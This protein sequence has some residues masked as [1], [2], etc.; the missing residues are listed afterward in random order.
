V[1]INLST[2]IGTLKLSNPIMTASGTFGY[3]DE[4]HETF[5]DISRLGAVVTK[6]ISLQPRAGNAMPRVIE[7]CSGMINAIGLA[8]V[9]LDA[10]LSDKLPFLNSVK[11]TVIVNVLGSSIEEYV[12]ICEQLNQAKNIAAIE[13]NISCPNVNSGGVHFGTQPKLTESVIRAVQAV[14]TLPL[15]VKLSPQVTSIADIARAAEN[16]GANAISL[17]NTVPAMVIDTKKRKP[18]LANKIGGLSGPAIKPIAIKQ[19]YDVY[20]NV[21]IP[22]IGMCGITCLND[23]IEFLLAGASAVQI[24]T[25]NFTDPMLASQLIDELANYCQAHSIS[26]ISKLIG[27]AHKD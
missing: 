27:Q 21:K 10:F 18:V 7:V 3:G 1:D 22:I 5:Y 24:G 25:A 19:V 11:A 15:I 17:I 9:G 13:L 12:S 14:N 20:D 8:N 16:G 2:S 6:G 23:V 4:F 26:C